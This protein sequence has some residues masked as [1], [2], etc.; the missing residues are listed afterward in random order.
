MAIGSPNGSYLKT[1][2]FKSSFA[3]ADFGIYSWSPLREDPVLV[4]FIY[5]RITQHGEAGGIRMKDRLPI[6]D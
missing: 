4:F 5:R 6:V 3:K 2:S 1:V